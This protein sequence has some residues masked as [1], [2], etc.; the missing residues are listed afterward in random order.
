MG[1]RTSDLS[2]IAD[3]AAFLLSSRAAKT[4][5]K[6]SAHTLVCCAQT[7][8]AAQPNLKTNRNMARSTAML[9]GVTSCQFAAHSPSRQELPMPDTHDGH[10]RRNLLAT[11]GRLSVAGA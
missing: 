9:P 10:N 8:A 11:L 3:R 7:S 2:G 6:H 5:T 1:R 4:G